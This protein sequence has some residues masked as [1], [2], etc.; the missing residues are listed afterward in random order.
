MER[1]EVQ[2]TILVL[3]SADDSS[4]TAAEAL[5]RGLRSESATLKDMKANLV[6]SSVASLDQRPVE[7]YEALRAELA[8]STVEFSELRT[9]LK[10]VI[11]E[12]NAAVARLEAQLD[13]HTVLAGAIADA[14]AADNSAAGT[15]SSLQGGTSVQYEA[16]R[17]HLRS[18]LKK[19][20]PPSEVRLHYMHQL[21]RLDFSNFADFSLCNLF[22]CWITR[23]KGCC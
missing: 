8:K 23:W 9:Y 6:N 13:E 4:V 20:F 22:M 3:P 15:A 7:C 17:S 14:A 18:F 11:T 21:S 1:S 10:H 16:L 12:E 5:Q 2:Q 19:H